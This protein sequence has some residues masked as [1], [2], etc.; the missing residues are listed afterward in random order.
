M[1]KKKSKS[2]PHRQSKACLNILPNRS[3][4][5][6]PSYPAGAI[7]RIL[8]ADSLARKYAQT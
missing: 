7:V 4:P 1:L 8:I 5:A 2:K 3:E 6:G